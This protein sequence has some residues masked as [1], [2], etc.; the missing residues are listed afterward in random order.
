MARNSLGSTTGGQ[1]DFARIPPSHVPRTAFN[2]NSGMKTTFDFGEICPIFVDETLPGDTM[3]MR[4][5]IFARLATQLKPVMDNMYVDRSQPPR[6]GQL[7]EILRRTNRPRR[8]DRLPGAPGYCR[9]WRLPSRIV[10]RPHRPASGNQLRNL[11]QQHV[12]QGDE[13]NME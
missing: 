9:S 7:A 12:R 5:T 13:P 11:S 1:H 10:L 2:R 8:F 6:L 4:P 3:H